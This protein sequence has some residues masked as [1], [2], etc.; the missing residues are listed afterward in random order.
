M[1]AV[2]G[3]AVGA[4]LNLALACDVRLAGRSALFDARFLSLPI[5]PGGGHL[6]ML[7]RLVGP[8]AAAAM[9]LFD[10]PVPGELAVQIGLAWRCVDDE[11]LRESAIEFCGKLTQSPTP[12]LARTIKQSLRASIGNIDHDAAVELEL[13]AQLDSMRHPAFRARMGQA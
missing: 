13:V 2:N 10:Q 5:H 9:T 8:Q 4:G 7:E 12:A 6:W 11:S 1:A 3:P